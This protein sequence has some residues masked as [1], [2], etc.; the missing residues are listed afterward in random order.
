MSEK[1]I[2]ISGHQYLGGLFIFFY[3]AVRTSLPL[4]I[5]ATLLVTAIAYFAAPQPAPIYRAQASVQGGRVAGTETMGL[6]A[7]A[8]RVNGQSFKRQVLQ[9]M[10]LPA[11]ESDRASRLFFDSLAARPE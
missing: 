4:M 8:A 10:N 6:Q 9:L 2:L 5:V 7:A 1:R 11:V 3:R